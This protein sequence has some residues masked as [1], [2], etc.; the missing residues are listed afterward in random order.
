MDWMGRSMRSEHGIHLMGPKCAHYPNTRTKHRI[1]SMEPKSVL[2]TP[3]PI[4]LFYLDNNKTSKRWTA[5]VVIFPLKSFTK[6]LI[7]Y[8][9]LGRFWV[10]WECNC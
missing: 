3:I 6:P 8:P 7:T 1:H 10:K 2:V 5:I 9:I 4:L